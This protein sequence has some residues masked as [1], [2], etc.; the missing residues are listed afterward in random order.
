MAGRKLIRYL[1]YYEPTEKHAAHSELFEVDGENGSVYL[2][3]GVCLIVTI[4][5][6]IYP[7]EMI[8]TYTPWHR[9]RRVEVTEYGNA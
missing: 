8:R 9:I 7:G 1:V 6:P 2:N 4:K 3:N 5:S